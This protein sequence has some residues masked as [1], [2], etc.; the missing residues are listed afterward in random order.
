M[1]TPREKMVALITAPLSLVI[2]GFLCATPL[3]TFSTPLPTLPP[4]LLPTLPPTSTPPPA[5]LPGNVIIPVEEMASSIPWLPVDPN[6]PPSTMVIVFNTSEPPFND[7]LVR[8]ALAAAVDRQAI[9][10]VA[11]VFGEK[12]VRP[13]TSFT[14]PGTLGLDLYGVVGIP[15]DPRHARDLLAQAGYANG[16][17][18][19]PMTVYTNRDEEGYRESIVT[20]VADMW[21]THLNIT[22]QVEVLSFDIWQAMIVDAPA[23]LYRVTWATDDTNDPDAFLGDIFRTGA[24]ANNSGFSNAD[25]DRLVDQAASYTDPAQRQAMYVAAERILCEEVIQLIPLFSSTGR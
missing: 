5:N 14:P 17:N 21:K 15:F 13:A 2:A 7:R 10:E 3:S 19:P 23:P 20:S 8:E 12:N 22:I 4:T 1:K 24:E 9:A 16:T 11:R 25:F 18:F 6:A